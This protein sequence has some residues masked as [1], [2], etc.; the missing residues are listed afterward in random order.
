MQYCLSLHWL[1]MSNIVLSLYYALRQ[2]AWPRLRHRVRIPSRKRKTFFLHQ[3]ALV[4]LAILKALAPLGARLVSLLLYWSD[5]QGSLKGHMTTVFFRVGALEKD[6]G[7]GRYVFSCSFVFL[8]SPF[9][10]LICFV[11]LL[12]IFLA[13][14]WIR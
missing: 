3:L 14:I 7:D 1:V 13:G 5:Y 2:A 12:S 10:L 9:V 11:F 6:Q 8:P 4:L